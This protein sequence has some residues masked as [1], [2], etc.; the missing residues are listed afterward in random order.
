MAYLTAV[1]DC[2]SNFIPNSFYCLNELTSQSKLVINNSNNS[3][4]K[5][6]SL[7]PKFTSSPCN[8]FS[9]ANN[10]DQS[11]PPSSRPLLRT[12][13][14]RKPIKLNDLKYCKLIGLNL[15]IPKD[16]QCCSVDCN[17]KLISTNTYQQ[18][19]H[20]HKHYHVS[21]TQDDNDLLLKY[22]PITIRNYVSIFDLDKGTFNG[23]KYK[24]HYLSNCLHKCRQL[25]QDSLCYLYLL[26][27]VVK[28]YVKVAFLYN[29][30]ILFDSG[31]RVYNEAKVRQRSISN[32]HPIK[33][34]R[35]N[36]KSNEA[37]ED[38][39]LLS[40]LSSSKTVLD[41]F[42]QSDQLKKERV[43]RY[44]SI[45]YVNNNLTSDTSSYSLTS[46]LSSLASAIIGGG[47]GGDGKN[48]K[49]LRRHSNNPQ[50]TS[51]EDIDLMRAILAN[52]TSSNY[53]ANANTDNASESLSE[54]SMENSSVLTANSINLSSNSNSSISFDDSDLN[55]VVYILKSLKIKQIYLYNLAMQKKK[56]RE[57][58]KL[59]KDLNS[60]ET[61]SS[62]FE[63][64]T[65]T[66][67]SA[68]S[69]TLLFNQRTLE[70]DK[71][72]DN[73]EYLNYLKEQKLFINAQIQS[74]VQLPLLIEYEELTL[75]HSKK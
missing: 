65:N 49:Q 16:G 61:K 21:K 34:S 1:L 62:T 22:V 33:T 51:Y 10:G 58:K 67:I 57:I 46:S 29:Y 56:L 50:T 59:L 69:S 71:N 73:K 70:A 43:L 35:L 6:Q 41:Q 63:T 72:F 30:S 31:E 20:Q 13:F 23:P 27:H 64:E 26:A 39:S 74:N 48:Y 38:N 11:Q 8:Q 2:L 53:N 25:P 45:D 60:N 54:F 15:L 12:I 52:V 3:P 32:T 47:G 55:I 5:H 75:F 19:Q 9:S 18:H 28:Y 7:S 36:H 68:G 44:Y 24:G 40:S 37:N 42:S 17:E 14:E 4:K 66:Q